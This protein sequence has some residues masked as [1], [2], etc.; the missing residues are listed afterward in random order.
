MPKREADYLRIAREYEAA[1]RAGH[2]PSGSQLPSLD[3]I[4]EEYGVSRSTVQRA[5]SILVYQGL[6]RGH[7][8]KA[9]FVTPEAP[10]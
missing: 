5:M 7:Q 1:I 4:A 8:G 9:L 10:T 2:L 6:V 3:A